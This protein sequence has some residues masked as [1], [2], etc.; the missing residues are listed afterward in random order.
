MVFGGGSVLVC[1]FVFSLFLF[2]LRFSACL[3]VY[4]LAY[5]GAWAWAW[6][7]LEQRALQ[8]VVVIL[9][10]EI[11]KVFSKVFLYTWMQ[12]SADKRLD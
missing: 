5:L 7:G 10:R 2:C 12:F 1:P 3:P 4:L 8:F 11:R 9:D 6:A